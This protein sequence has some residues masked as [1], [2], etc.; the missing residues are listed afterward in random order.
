[1]LSSKKGAVR[2]WRFIDLETEP[3]VFTGYPKKTP[4]MVLDT[5]AWYYPSL[6]SV[7]S[8]L[9]YK[10]HNIKLQTPCIWVSEEK[11]SEDKWLV[12]TRIKSSINGLYSSSFYVRKKLTQDDLNSG[13]FII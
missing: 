5:I 3:T 2:K 12:K 4:G 7:I 6:V 8:Q 10:V 11:I 1:M 13:R 9:L